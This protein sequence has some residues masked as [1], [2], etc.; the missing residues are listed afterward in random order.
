MMKAAGGFVTGAALTLVVFGVWVVPMIAN[1]RYQA[2]LVTGRT[3]AE[4]DIAHKIR[5]VLGDDF[6]RNE[7]KDAFYSIKDIMVVVVNRNGTKTL[8]LYE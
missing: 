7:Q 2:G 5:S 8:R 6:N 1:D 4:V 3:N